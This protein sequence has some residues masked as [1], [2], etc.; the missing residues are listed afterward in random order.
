MTLIERQR[1][2][3]GSRRS[4]RSP[5]REL[6][7]GWVLAALHRGRSL[8]EGGLTGVTLHPAWQA[9]LI[10]EAVQHLETAALG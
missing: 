1:D 10:A 3:G 5:S 2:R 8:W 6:Q 7:P 9:W 4:R